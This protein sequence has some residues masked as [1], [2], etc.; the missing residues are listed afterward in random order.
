MINKIKESK[1]FYFASDFLEFKG[2][3]LTSSSKKLVKLSKSNQ[4]LITPHLA[5]ASL[6]SWNICEE[7]LAKLIT[8]YEK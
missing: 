1:L 2:R 4:I 5:G 7:Y 8:K 3:V 6:E